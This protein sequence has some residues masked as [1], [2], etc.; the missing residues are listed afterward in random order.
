VPQQL[1]K[2]VGIFLIRSYQAGI[3]PWL[4]PACRFE[5]TCSRYALE[6]IARHGMSRGGWLAARRLAR[7]HPLGDSGYDPVP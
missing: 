5:P 1:A 6:A 2:K 3:S 4:P 7:C